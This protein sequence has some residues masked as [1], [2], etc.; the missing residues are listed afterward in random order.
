[1]REYYSITELTREFDISTRTLALL[2]GRGAD[3]AGPA[4]PHAAVPPVR[5]ASHQ[6]DHARQAARL[7][8]HRD[9]RNHPDVQGA[10][11]RGGPAQADDP[12]ASRRSAR[13][14]ARSGATSKRRWPSST[15]PRNPASSGWP[16]S[17]SIPE[18]AN[19]DRCSCRIATR[20]DLKSS[21]ARAWRSRGTSCRIAPSGCFSSRSIASFCVT[22]AAIDREQDEPGDPGD[23]PDADHQQ[24]VGEIDRVAGEGERARRDQMLAGLR[25]A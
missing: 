3:P 6:A 5:P 4:R 11:G 1:M 14:C 7:L 21:A 19:R 20:F 17:A 22:K 9:P 24:R 2:R 15:R 12:A 23:Q 10:A 16:S 18:R 8:D 13:I 25:S